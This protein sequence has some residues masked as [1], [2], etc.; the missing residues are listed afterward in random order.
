MT[1]MQ[2]LISSVLLSH[3]SLRR[4]VRVNP[5]QNPAKVCSSFVLSRI[6]YH[7]ELNQI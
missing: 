4:E 6:L 2:G 5:T 7:L 3:F 1:I